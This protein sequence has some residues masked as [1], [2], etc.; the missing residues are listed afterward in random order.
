MTITAKYAGTCNRCHG[1]IDP[2]TAINWERGKGSSHVTCPAAG[3]P[4]T[5]A[6]STGTGKCAKC[7]A[8]CKPQYPTCFRCSGKR[9]TKCFGCGETLP[10][11]EQSH[12]V[13]RCADCRDGGGN[14][15]G[16]QSYYDRNGN[17]VLGDDD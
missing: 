3:A 1:S 12:G 8:A 17:F 9:S 5:S 11:W 4:K 16:G 7:G 13:R 15:H 2:G 10:P 6:A 14:A